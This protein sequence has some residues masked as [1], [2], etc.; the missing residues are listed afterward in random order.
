MAKKIY[1]DG[2]YT[3][4][5]I[6]SEQEH[7]IRQKNT[8]SSK[9]R[10]CRYCD[11]KLLIKIDDA[12]IGKGR[13]WEIDDERDYEK[14]L[15]LRTIKQQY[16]CLDCYKKPLEEREIILDKKLNRKSLFWNFM[17]ILV[18]IGFFGLIGYFVWIIIFY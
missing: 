12:Y 9:E 4:E 15:Q 2:R 1:R 7:H 18:V 5:E 17:R 11:K 14:K 6:L 13:V 10:K 16:A 3:G 8:H